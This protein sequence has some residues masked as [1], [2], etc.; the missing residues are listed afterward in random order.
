MAPVDARKALPCFD[1]PEL[2]ANFT[3][4]ILRKNNMT[5]ISNTPLVSSDEMYVSGWSSGCAVTSTIEPIA[6][7]MCQSAELWASAVV[8]DGLSAAVSAS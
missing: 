5:A 4:R 1:E 8:G 2:K 6:Q 7:H 3:L